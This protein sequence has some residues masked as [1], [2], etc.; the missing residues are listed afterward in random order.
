MKL[1]TFLIVLCLVVLCLATVS[2]ATTFTPN[3]KTLHGQVPARAWVVISL[4]GCGSFVPVI[5]SGATLPA[6]IS[7]YPD[8]MGAIRATV[9]DEAG[10]TCGTSTGTTYYHVPKSPSRTVAEADY[11]IATFNLNSAA[12]KPG[13]AQIPAGRNQWKGARSSS[14]QYLH[15]DAVSYGGPSYMAVVGNTNIT[16]GTDGTKWA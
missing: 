4:T 1:L 15:Y 11:D 10:Y 3:L 14:T 16:L 6:P 7:L 13:T 8:N 12:P 5:G 2:G 9:Q